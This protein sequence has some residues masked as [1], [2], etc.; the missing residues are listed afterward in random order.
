METCKVCGRT[1]RGALCFW[2]T[3][4]Y[5]PGCGIVLLGKATVCCPSCYE[6]RIEALREKLANRA[7]NQ[8]YEDSTEVIYPPGE[9]SPLMEKKCRGNYPNGKQIIHKGNHLS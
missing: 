1:R 7:S 8:E 6:K 5:C 2:C 9:L 4:S 3:P